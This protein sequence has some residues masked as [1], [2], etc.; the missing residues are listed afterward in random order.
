MISNSSVKPKNKK[1][2]RNLACLLFSDFHLRVCLHDD[3]MVNK[4]VIVVATHCNTK[5]SK[6]E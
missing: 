5:Y 4:L 3:I 1:M 2:L 6:S